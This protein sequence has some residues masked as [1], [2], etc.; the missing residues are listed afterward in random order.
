MQCRSSCF[1]ARMHWHK[2][3]HRPNEFWRALKRTPCSRAPCLESATGKAGDA[4]AL[5]LCSATIMRQYASSM[6]QRTNYYAEKAR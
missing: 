5:D 3:T 6:A 4:R 1:Y 2:Q